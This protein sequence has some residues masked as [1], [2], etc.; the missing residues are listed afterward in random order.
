MGLNKVSAIIVDDEQEAIDLLLEVL[1]DNPQV[2]VLATCTDAMKAPEIILPMRPDLLFLD[3]QMPG[4]DGF[5]VLETVNSTGFYPKVIFIT[6]YDKFAIRA[7]KHAALDYLLKPVNPDELTQALSRLTTVTTEKL[8]V[9]I[10]QLLHKID[11]NKKLKFNTRTG[12][13]IINTADI[14]YCKADRNYTEIY[15]ND[16]RIEVL[17]HTLKHI[18]EVLN[19][20]HFF[21]GSRS[22]LINLDYLV[23]AERTKKQ[24]TLQINDDFINLSLPGNQIKTLERL[25]K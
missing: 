11:S 20:D 9:C 2:N 15:L 17:T 10:E 19:F 21:R 25:K 14:V 4:Q 24:I 22:L 8:Q 18:S 3:I 5:R 1:K 23:K 6:G 13:I 12:F 16:G 7:I